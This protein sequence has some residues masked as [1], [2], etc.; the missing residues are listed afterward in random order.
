MLVRIV[1]LNPMVADRVD[2]S[3]VTKCP[4]VSMA[5]YSALSTLFLQTACF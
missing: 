1:C 3:V 2:I 5:M 4:Y